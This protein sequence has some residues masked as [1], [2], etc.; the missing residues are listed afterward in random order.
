[1]ECSFIFEVEEKRKH[2]ISMV[3]IYLFLFVTKDKIHYIK[4]IKEEYQCVT[5]N[6]D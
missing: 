5:K 6:D 4:F 2:G 3:R 1:M